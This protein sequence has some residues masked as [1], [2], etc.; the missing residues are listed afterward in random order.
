M[1]QSS[2]DQ[3]RAGL[4]VAT[5][6]LSG[7]FLQWLYHLPGPQ[8]LLLDPVL[9]INK[10]GEAKD[11]MGSLIEIRPES[12]H[13]PLAKTQSPVSTQLKGRLENGPRW[14]RIQGLMKYSIISVMR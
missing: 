3:E 1:L 2:A 6:G 9:T 5:E 10:P 14:K 11:H 4:H 12:G 13:L 8:S 7:L